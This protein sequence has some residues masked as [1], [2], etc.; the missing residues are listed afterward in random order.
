MYKAWL[1]VIWTIVLLTT[2]ARR[3]FFLSPSSDRCSRPTW[4]YEH[5]TNPTRQICNRDPSRSMYGRIAKPLQPSLLV[6]D[7]QTGE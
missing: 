3:T 4:E 2:Q 7:H 5:E 6:A 1:Q